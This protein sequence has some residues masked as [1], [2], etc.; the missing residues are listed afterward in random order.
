MG[1]CTAALLS[2]YAALC[3]ALVSK[4]FYEDAQ[5]AGIIYLLDPSQLTHSSFQGIKE[6]H[7][8]Q[9]HVK[10][11]SRKNIRRSHH[12]RKLGKGC[13]KDWNKEHNGNPTAM[14]QYHRFYAY[15]RGPL[16]QRPSLK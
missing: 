2:H 6:Q 15:I 11:P 4:Q 16:H 3:C 8:K 1:E 5:A 13:P 10:D 14:T 7:T 9:Q 12:P